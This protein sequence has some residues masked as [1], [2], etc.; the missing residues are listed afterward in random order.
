M[1]S[2]PPV[3]Q[4]RI[5]LLDLQ[6]IALTIEIS[7]RMTT[8]HIVSHQGMVRVIQQLAKT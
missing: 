8:S 6:P 7:D 4:V 1:T 5:S 3:S 2:E